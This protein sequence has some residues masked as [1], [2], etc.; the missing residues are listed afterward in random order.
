[1]KGI[2][3]NMPIYE[4]KCEDCQ[5]KF[6][7]SGTFH[8]LLGLRPICPNCCGNKVK[9]LISIPFIHY[10]GQGFYSNDSKDSK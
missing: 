7:V 8:A 9:K 2:Q 5:T 4:Y 1:M 6:E 3:I 10:K